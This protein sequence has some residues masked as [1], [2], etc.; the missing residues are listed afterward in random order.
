[1][2][3]RIGSFQNNPDLWPELRDEADFYALDGLVSMLKVT[4]SCS[5]DKD[6]GRGIIYYVGTNK[7]KEEYTN[8]YTRN[9]VDVAGWIAYDDESLV[10]VDGLII[11]R[12]SCLETGVD[13]AREY[14]V[15]QSMAFRPCCPVNVHHRACLHMLIY[16][17]FGIPNALLAETCWLAG[18]GWLLR[19]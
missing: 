7:G 9:V 19:F 12:M 17:E 6:G 14:L 15:Q 8:P 4:F 11:Q 13:I 16:R 1:V 10:N 5:P 18:R 3:S 2:S